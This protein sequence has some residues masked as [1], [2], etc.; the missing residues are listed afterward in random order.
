MTFDWQTEYA[1]A[2]EAFGGD[3]PSATLEQDILEAFQE[4]PQAVTNAITKIAKGY[5]SGRIHSPW[6]ALKAE[7]PKQVARDVRVGD[8]SEKARAVANAE[9]W[10][11]TSGMWYPTST[12]MLQALFAV[13]E[14]TAPLEF[15]EELESTTRD[16]P[17]R[18]LYD[19][20]LRASI[21]RTRAEGQQPVPESV[22]GPLGKF[23]DVSRTR[24]VALWRE[25][26]PLALQAEA[27]ELERARRW[28]EARDVRDQTK[29]GQ[30]VGEV[31]RLRALALRVAEKPWVMT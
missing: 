5:S 9:Q 10:M 17:G 25:L 31:A 18:A 30:P 16:E 19:G 26:R 7:I 15:L 23:Q 20:L 11:R 12:E 14:L 1:R 29:P 8:G 13:E 4:H 21:E 24:M 27:D 28:R 3:T 22:E 2:L 6:G